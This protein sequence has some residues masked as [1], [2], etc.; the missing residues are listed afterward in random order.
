MGSDSAPQVV[1]SFLLLYFVHLRK[2][3]LF[4]LR[5]WCLIRVIPSL[6]LETAEARHLPLTARIFCFA[7]DNEMI[8]ACM[9]RPVVTVAIIAI[10][11]VN[12][13]V[14]H[15]ARV[16][17]ARCSIYDIYIDNS[18]L[19]YSLANG[20]W[21]QT[22]YRRRCMIRRAFSLLIWQLRKANLIA[23]AAGQDVVEPCV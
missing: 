10:A 22:C 17:T 9:L 7:V 21:F 5:A 16:S 14:S 20:G 15:I 8:W 3:F 11:V 18:Y 4:Y 13:L 12:Y 2:K 1:D 6:F 19:V 23:R